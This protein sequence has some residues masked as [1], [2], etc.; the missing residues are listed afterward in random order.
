MHTR[1]GGAAH[2]NIFYFLIILVMFFGVLGFGYVQLTDN[3]VLE[4]ENAALRLE[5]A[6]LDVNNWLLQH[7]SEDISEAIDLPGAGPILQ[8][9]SR[10]PPA[11]R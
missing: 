1:Q 5:N 7:Y 11:D 4:T 6:Q 3:A 9:M 2:I 8:P 10:P